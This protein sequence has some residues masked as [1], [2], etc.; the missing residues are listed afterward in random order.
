MN[1]QIE[2]LK[3][4]APFLRLYRNKTFVIKLGGS[5]LTG[6]EI[7]DSVAMQCALLKVLGIR[8]VLVHG[9]GAQ[10]SE[11]SRRLGF[12]P[13]IVAGRRVTDDAALE[14][15]KMTFA[16]KVNVELLSALRRQGAMAVGLSG[17]DA[18]L[19]LAN[20]RPPVSI[21]DDD[22]AKRNVDFGHVGD[23]K[24]V[25][26]MILNDLLD[27]GYLPVV[28]SLGADDKGRPLNINA[29]TM[30]EAIATSM[31]AKKLMYLTDQSGILRDPHD[32][33]TLIPFADSQDLQSL[34]ASGV[35][36]GGMRPKVEACIRASTSGVK[37][38]HIIDGAA[39]DSLL[40]E[41]LTG[42]GCGTMIVGEREKKLYQEQKLV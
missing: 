40:T 25:N 21:L 27:K 13:E 38:T 1:G 14:V 26:T 36:S 23:V 5:I 12:E 37:R 39:P 19:I 3:M 2:F 28:A 18:D 41:I 24:S 30:A 20:R 4:A 35:V 9:G 16:G 33:S 31:Q 42:E 22:G 17:I 11:L 10:A 7:L 29:D 15:V 8:L 32:P 34:I 6:D